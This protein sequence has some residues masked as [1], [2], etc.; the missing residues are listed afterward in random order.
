VWD[1]GEQP[2]RIVEFTDVIW[3]KISGDGSWIVYLRGDYDTAVD[4]WAVKTDGSHNQLVLNTGGMQEISSTEA[5]IPYP[6]R[7][8]TDWIPGSSALLFRMCATTMDK[9]EAELDR[10]IW[11]LDVST[12]ESSLYG[13][14]NFMISPNGQHVVLLEEG[15][16]DIYHSEGG[17]L[18]R[19]VHQEPE[20]S[21]GEL[22]SLFQQ[23]H[24]SLDGSHFLIVQPESEDVKDEDAAFRVDRVWVDERPS[25][26]LG[27]YPGYIYS[28]HFSPDNQFMAYKHML[29]F[30]ENRSELH[31]VNLDLGEDIDYFEGRHIG[32]Y[33]WS[34]NAYNFTFFDGLDTYL[35]DICLLPDQAQ[36]LRGPNSYI[37]YEWVCGDALLASQK[38]ESIGLSFEFVGDSDDRSNFHLAEFY[39]TICIQGD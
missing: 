32:L 13:A 25:E 30:D 21:S 37:D 10:R 3:L 20:L 35:S 6:C 39:D 29:D 31:L 7:R 28:V 2:I 15:R 24:W 27:S 18:R 16:I 26:F 38:D 19:N 5:G 11:K 23:A 34:P 22:N 12:G 8:Y 17:I 9:R 33:E 1:Q 4:I 14:G 36:L